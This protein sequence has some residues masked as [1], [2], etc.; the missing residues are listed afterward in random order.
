VD[1]ES[2]QV[3]FA[4]LA[5]VAGVGGVGFAAAR[6]VPWTPARRLGTVLAP[7]ATWLAWLVAALSTLGSLYFSEVAHFTPCK[8]CW[9][10]RICMY[11]LSVILLVGAR[12]RD[13][14]VVWYA[15][16]FAVVGLAVSSYH[17]LIEWYPTLEATS[18]DLSAPCTQVWFR[19]FG[20][21][22]LAFMAGCGFIAIIALLTCRFT[23]NEPIPPATPD[24][25]E[26]H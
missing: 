14:R 22:S 2:M 11:P 17:Y 18:C 5:L 16:P 21:V 19:S 1:R 10:Q 4:L 20:F 25:S 12:S 3:F 9:Y 15:L 6:L 26:E 24:C 7:S 13:R 23:S 8:L